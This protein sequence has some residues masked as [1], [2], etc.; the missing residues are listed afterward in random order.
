MIIS[1]NYPDGR[2]STENRDSDLRRVI[3]QSTANIFTQVRSWWKS[4][5]NKDQNEKLF[6]AENSQN[7]EPEQNEAI[8][9]VK[10]P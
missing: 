3:T 8:E 6:W 7:N 10:H 9:I 4:R 1:I 5:F 2:F